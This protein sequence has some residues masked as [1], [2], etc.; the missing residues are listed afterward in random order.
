MEFSFCRLGHASGVGLGGDG[1]GQK[2]LVWGFAMAPHLLHVLV[3]IKR[4]KLAK[5][6]RNV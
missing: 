1:G 3:R 2:H 5:D 6:C 4:K